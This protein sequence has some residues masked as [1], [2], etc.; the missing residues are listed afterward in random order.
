MLKELWLLLLIASVA[1]SAAIHYS[2][3]GPQRLL[4]IVPL[5]YGRRF[6]QPKKYRQDCAVCHDLY[7]KHPELLKGIAEGDNKSLEELPAI[8]DELQLH[9]NACKS[10]AKVESIKR[11]I[12]FIDHQ[13]KD[14]ADMFCVSIS[15]C[16]G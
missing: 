11:A 15:F 5:S 1:N 14:A 10:L 8:C 7:F 16:T 4:E 2:E 3:L 12:H 13:S 9:P 6:S